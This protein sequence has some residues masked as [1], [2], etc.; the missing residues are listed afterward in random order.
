MDEKGLTIRFKPLKDKSSWQVM[1]FVQGKKKP[2]RFYTIK[3]IK[4][5]YGKYEIC[6]NC[7]RKF[8]RCKGGEQCHHEEAFEKYMSK[9]LDSGEAKEITA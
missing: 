4:N 2:Q 1:V 5:A 8:Y 9:L 7:P 6:C 3:I